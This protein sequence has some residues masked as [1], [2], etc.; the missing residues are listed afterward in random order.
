[1]KY[2]DKKCEK[3]DVKFVGTA[4]SKYCIICKD[5]IRSLRIVANNKKLKGKAK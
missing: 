2:Y 5:I 3:C 1:M 4:S